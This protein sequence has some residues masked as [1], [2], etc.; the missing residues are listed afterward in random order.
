MSR[1]RL[2]AAFLLHQTCSPTERQA[3]FLLNQV[4]HDSDWRMT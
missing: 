2:N 3:V 1:R 4:A